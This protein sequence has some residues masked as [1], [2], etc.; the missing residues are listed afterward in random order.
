[1]IGEHP[2]LAAE[3]RALE[4]WCGGDPSGFL[5]LCDAEV[6]YFEPFRAARIDGLAALTAHYEGLRGQV[7][8]RSWE[9]VEPR[10]VEHG[11]VAILSYRFHSVAES[12]AAMRWQ[13]SEVYRLDGE[14][15]RLLHTHW[16]LLGA[17]VA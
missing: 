9:I 1:M 3:R 14:G 10:V 2:V 11:A 4:R 6:G 5:E 7:R 15:P 8:V 16:S 12:G 17:E 13:A